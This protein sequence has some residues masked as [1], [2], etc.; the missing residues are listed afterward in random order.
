MLEF[1]QQIP[2]WF[3]YI[4]LFFTSLMKSYYG[5]TF[6]AI[7]NHSYI[8]MLAI[9]FS[10]SIFSILL[11]YRFRNLIL[12]LL[13]KKSK[14][15]NGY[16]PKLKKALILWNKYGIYGIAAISPVLISIPIGVLISAHF[17]TSKSLIF[18]TLAVSTFFWI[19][20]FYF[21]T[22]LGILQV[23]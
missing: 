18:S 12:N 9:N 1:L 16:N 15:G 20:F 23:I 10:A 22:K 2:E 5:S 21:L 11:S 4:V 7:F 3:Q 19:N 17:R 14:T 6:S 13:K 8:V